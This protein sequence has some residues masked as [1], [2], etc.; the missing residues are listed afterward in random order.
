[1]PARGQGLWEEKE[2]RNSL[3]KQTHKQTYKQGLCLLR[4]RK[5]PFSPWPWAPRASSRPGARGSVLTVILGPGFPKATCDPRLQCRMGSGAAV[6]LTHPGVCEGVGSFLFPERSWVGS[7]ERPRH[8][9]PAT[10]PGW[11]S[12]SLPLSPALLR[13]H[14]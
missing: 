4:K 5:G 10:R 13:R 9:G 12:L 8:L 11:V 7:S 3:G 6:C 1:M 2:N 14:L